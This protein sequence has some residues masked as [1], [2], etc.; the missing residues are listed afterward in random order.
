MVK[1]IALVLACIA[2]AAVAEPLMTEWGARV[3]PENAWREYPRPNLVRPQWQNL[4]GLW[5]YAV[6]GREDTPPPKWEGEI[7]VPFCIESSLSRV[8]RLLTDTEL[9]WYRRTFTAE[10]KAD[11]RLLLHFGAVDFRAQVF[12]NGIEVTDVPHEGGNLPFTLDITGAVTNGENELRVVVWDPTNA[13]GSFQAAGKQDIHPQ[14][15]AYTRVSGI[16]QTVWMESV[17]RTYIAGYTVVTDI[18]KG[19]VAVTVDAEG[20]LP[21]AAVTV[22]AVKD[23]KAVTEAKAGRVGEPVVLTI[24]NPQLWS[25][26]TP[27]L[28][29]LK[30]TLAADGAEDTATGYFGMR[31]IEAKPDERGVPRFYL[32]HKKVFMSGTLDQ[33][34]WP[35]GL[36]T[37]PSDDA[38]AADIRLLKSLGFNMM[39]KHLKVE[40]LRYYWLCD[41]LGIIV[42]QDMIS[43]GGE[44]NRRYALFRR[45]LKGMMD[46]LQTFPCIV[47]WNPYNEGYGQPASAF[48]SNSVSQW[49]RR[50]DPTRLLSGPSGGHD[51]GVGDTLDMHNYPGPGMYPV[52]KDRISV[53]GEFGGLGLVMEGHTWNSAKDS[54]GYVTDAAPEASFVRFSNLY[55]Q[56]KRLAM[57]GLGGS[58]YTQTTDV[59]GEING[60]VT[61]D[62]KRVKYDVAKVAALNKAVIEA[63]EATRFPEYV[64]LLKV[65]ATEAG[66]W[67]YAVEKPADGWEKTDFDDTAWKS[68]EGGFG[69]KGISVNHPAAKVR[70]VWN[71][72]DI[73]LR[74]AFEYNGEAASDEVMLNIFYD[75]DATVWLNGEMLANLPGFF[76]DYEHV[77]LPAS[78]LKSVLRKGRN[79][80]AIHL[81]NA[82]GDAYIDAGID[83]VTYK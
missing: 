13:N 79:V 21:G 51:F 78:V 28:Y 32:N 67:R 42:W 55:I 71:N 7:L 20:N 24:E 36:L 75:E 61:Y 38:M 50:Y 40:P 16:W 74:R 57:E 68:G 73:W 41:R 66:A 14:G 17:P 58:V 15:C 10:M 46:A 9:L 35:D 52:M 39:R 76:T 53:L 62:R 5:Q 48:L 63:A 2:G 80:L 27:N 60:L 44:P 34:W 25:P 3:T 11:Q 12:V 64:P 37:P 65:S 19:T 18:D 59:E 22:A 4:N 33:G 45:E 30:L 43:G 26:E 54:W 70:T 72:G 31:K 6:R 56:L 47:M 23:G 82:A 1:Q 81:S 83:F 49:I 29:D 77:A 8:K 69:N